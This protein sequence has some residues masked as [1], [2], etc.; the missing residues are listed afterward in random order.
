[1]INIPAFRKSFQVEAVPQEGIVVSHESG[2]LVFG[3]AI[4]QAVTPLIHGKRSADEIADA[5]AGRFSRENVYYTLQS[6]Q[7]Q[8]LVYDKST[9]DNSALPASWHY[10]VGDLDR[11]QR[12]VRQ[13]PISVVATAGLGI[14]P[15]LQIFAQYDLKI[16]KDGSFLVVFAGDYLEAELAEIN[17]KSLESGLPWMLVKPVGTLAFIGPIFRPGRSACWE[18]LAERLRRRREIERYG[19]NHGAAC[20]ASAAPFNPAA[21]AVQSIATLQTAKWVA[22]G[23]NP[24]LEGKI[25]SLDLTSLVTC[26]HVVSKRPC[27]AACGRPAPNKPRWPLLDNRSRQSS[28]IPVI[29]FS[30]QR[31][32]TLT[33]S[34]ISAQLPASCQSSS[35]FAR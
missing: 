11:A 23:E 8:G 29:A 9:L 31:R 30:R 4:E 19:R 34:I 1:M 6:M 27:C 15:D 17:R 25:V 16:E 2:Q 12:A 14:A 18:C 35:R 28:I 21:S 20:I 7:Q 22:T 26:T 5:L 33:T 32:P 3:G 13:T 10:L 24:L